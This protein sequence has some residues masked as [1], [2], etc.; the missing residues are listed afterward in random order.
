M[1]EDKVFRGTTT[2]GLVCRE[3]VVLATEKRA[4]MG[5]FIAS[6]AAR[7]IYQVADRIAMTTAGIVGDAQFLARLISVETKIYETRREEKPTVRAVATL[8]SNILN[9]YR[10]F[11]YLVQLLIG[12]VD[13]YGA[14][15]YSID[16]IG[17]AIEEKDIVATGS[18]SPTAYGVLEDRFSPDMKIDEALELAIRAIWSAMRRDAASGDGIDAVKITKDEY[19]QLKPEEIDE[20]IAKFRN[21]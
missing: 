15:I 17:G 14:S 16:P 4:T 5:H 3:G 1:I 9:T 11:P 2:V 20:I 18:G 7:K 21:R 19:Y 12:G 10:W 8:T 13:K 6:R